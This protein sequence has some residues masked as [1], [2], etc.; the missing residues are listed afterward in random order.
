MG[1]YPGA[2]QTLPV[3]DQG[4]RVSPGPISRG[5]LRRR[6]RK[7]VQARAT[8]ALTGRSLTGGFLPAVT[9]VAMMDSGTWTGGVHGGVPRVQ[10]RARVTC[11]Y[12]CPGYTTLYRTT[13]SP[14]SPACPAP[15]SSG[16]PLSCTTVTVRLP[17][18]AQRVPA[19]RGIPGYS[20][21]GKKDSWVILAAGG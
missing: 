7:D 19:G 18:A 11:L 1:V 6:S 10:Y 4:A 13:V 12:T 9:A 2:I 8:Q 3:L 5:S 16:F 17:I 21:R 15:S 14:P 20:S